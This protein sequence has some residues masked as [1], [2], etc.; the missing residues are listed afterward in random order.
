MPRSPS[1]LF[2][3]FAAWLVPGG[4]HF[5]L[6]RTTS[7]IVFFLVVSVT[8]F[9]G[10]YLTDFTNVSPERH[11]FY[12][13]AHILNGGETL[14]ASYLTRGIPEDHVPRHLGTSTE[15]IGTLYSAVAALLNVIVVMDAYGRITGV[16]KDEAE[17]AADEPDAGGDS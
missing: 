11:G 10:M 13:L 12:F 15:D 5:V 6:G 2:V 17:E 8:F 16:T 1:P 7:A 4:G 9:G 3:V 14:I